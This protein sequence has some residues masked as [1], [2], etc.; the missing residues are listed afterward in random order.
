MFQND[1]CLEVLA[2]G[3]RYSR[4]LN[5]GN[6][7][8][9]IGVVVLFDQ[10]AHTERW[11]RK[12]TPT[13]PARSAK[14]TRVINGVTDVATRSPSHIRKLV[15]LKQKK[16]LY[17]FLSFF[18]CQ[19]PFLL[20]PYNRFEDISNITDKFSITKIHSFSSSNVWVIY[21]WSP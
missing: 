12:G 3:H 2:V 10:Q 4:T 21:V 20:W 7:P 9:S 19:H 11:G 1:F 14:L 5:Q 8:P 13:S 18:Q 15:I 17:N 6:G 16:W